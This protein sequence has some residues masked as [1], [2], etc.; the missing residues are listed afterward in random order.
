M[1]NHKLEQLYF[2]GTSISVEG[3]VGRAFSKLICDTSSIN[4][5]YL[6]KYHTLRYVTQLSNTAQLKPIFKLNGKGDKKEVAM[7][8]ILQHHNDFDMTPFFEWEFKVLPLI[9][10][11]FERASSIKSKSKPKD[12]EPKIGPRK[13]SSVYQFV[14]GMP[15][16]YVETRLRKELE[17]VKSKESQM[18][19]EE[20]LLRQEQLM[21]DLKLQRLRQRKQPVKDQKESLMEKLAR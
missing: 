13:L 15:L 8:K 9:I 21:L 10:N 17:D 14:R 20:L 6:S 1:D 12:F 11:W 19:E 2:N 3:Q 16:L 4:S 5:T 7:V 18:E